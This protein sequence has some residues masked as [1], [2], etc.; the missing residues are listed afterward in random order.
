LLH[1]EYA[2]TQREMTDEAA[3]NHETVMEELQAL[4]KN[5]EEAS[6]TKEIEEVQRT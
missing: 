1:G 4:C 3:A 2:L 6:G 5:L